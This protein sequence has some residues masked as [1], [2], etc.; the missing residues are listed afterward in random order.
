MLFKTSQ[1]QDGIEQY[2]ALKENEANVLAHTKKLVKRLTW[3]AP[4][5]LGIIVGT[6]SSSLIGLFI[7]AVLG[8]GIKYILEELNNEG[9]ELAKYFA[10]YQHAQIQTQQEKELLLKLLSNETF[11]LNFLVQLAQYHAPG[12]TEK[13]MQLKLYV[14]K[15]YVKLKEDF[16]HTRTEEAFKDIVNFF[17]TLKVWNGTTPLVDYAEVSFEHRYQEYLRNHD[18]L[19]AES[20]YLKSVL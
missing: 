20:M 11:Q 3:F 4:V 15:L 14:E 12:F 18:L 1:T 16:A 10:Q 2:L 13:E 7:G 9:T 17:E 5:L 19:D 6:L 8:A